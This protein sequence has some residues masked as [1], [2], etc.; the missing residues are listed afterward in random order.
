MKLSNI[1][2]LILSEDIRRRASG[3]SSSHV[4]NSTLNTE[5][6]GRTTH[7]SQNDRGRSKSRGK[8]QTKFRSDIVCWNCDKKGHFT[9]QCK[10]P[11]K[12]MS[13]KNERHDE[14]SANAATYEFD[15][16]LICSL[17]SFV[18]SWVMDSSASFH[19]TPSK[20]LLSNY[21][22]GRFGKVYLA[23]GKPLDNVGRGDI[24]IRTSSGTLW[25]LN[26]VRHIPALKKINIYRTV[27]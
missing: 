21:V 10:A 5:S 26:N 2:N 19:T 14:E 16:A 13:H 9:N 1:R 15:D 8:G 24:D 3:E 4:S 7:K 25:T 6:R 18:D 11:K 23:D 20:E 22:S 17:D 12:N 27:G